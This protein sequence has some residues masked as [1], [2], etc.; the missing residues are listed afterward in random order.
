MFFWGEV[1]QWCW[2]GGLGYGTGPVIKGKENEN[3]TEQYYNV[4]VFRF[5]RY[6]SSWKTEERTEF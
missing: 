4:H 5:K 6:I 2:G 3:I 1:I